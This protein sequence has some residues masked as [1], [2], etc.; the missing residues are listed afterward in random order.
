MSFLKNLVAISAIAVLSGC[1]S[2]VAFTEMNPA[3]QAVDPSQG[4]IYFYRPSALGA[5]VKPKIKL[6]D[7][8][9]AVSTARGFTFVDRPAGDY[10]VETSTEVDRRLS[11]VLRSG[12]TR[13]VRQSIN[14]GFFVGHVYPELVEAAEAR[15]E[16]SC[17]KWVE[18]QTP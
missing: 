16:L 3:A 14:M 11:F 6:N 2:G 17:C 18:P 12:E 5:A 15:D 10:V 9:I 13:Y 4:R 1:A 8:V 7:E